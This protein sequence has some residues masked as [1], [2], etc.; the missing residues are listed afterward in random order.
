M[1][2]ES[3][4]SDLTFCLTELKGGEKHSNPNFKNYATT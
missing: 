4:N 1:G 3:T 2:E